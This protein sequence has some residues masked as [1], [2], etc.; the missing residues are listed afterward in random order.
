MVLA[1]VQGAYRLSEVGNTKT[2]SHGPRESMVR[3]GRRFSPR[4][5]GDS[6]DRFD[7]RLDFDV[8]SLD[9]GGP[10]VEP[11]RV[12]RSVV[13]DQLRSLGSGRCEQVSGW[14]KRTSSSGGSDLAQASLDMEPCDSASVHVQT[15]DVVV[16]QAI[17]DPTVVVA[18]NLSNCGDEFAKKCRF[19]HEPK[20]FLA[21]SEFDCRS[22]VFKID[23]VS[24]AIVM[25]DDGSYVT[26]HM[27][28]VH[29]NLA[30][31]ER[32]LV[33]KLIGRRLPYLVLSNELK[34]KWSMFEDF[35]L[36]SISPD[37]FIY[38]FE[39]AEAWDAVLMGGPWVVGGFIIGLDR[40]SFSFSPQSMLL[41]LDNLYGLMLKLTAG[42]EL[43][44]LVFA[45]GWI[46]VPSFLPELRS[47]GFMASF[48]NRQNMRGSLTFASNV[49]LFGT[50]LVN[51]QMLLN[52]PNSPLINLKVVLLKC[53]NALSSLIVVLPR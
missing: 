22:D 4:S 24:K 28:L 29:V 26:L 2:S 19:L 16:S 3:S 39:S 36:V 38:L 48:S 44:L 7:S 53:V 20:D 41:S 8:N 35:H 45:C 51:V 30:R 42:G 34:R 5:D 14:G 17:V 15:S 6:D 47:L 11:E 33:G 32:G 13:D 21:C 43:L 23:D 10:S 46:M 50:I 27:E 1:T 31:L 37:S 52:P 40:W 12:L 18:T 49:A 9:A 25:S